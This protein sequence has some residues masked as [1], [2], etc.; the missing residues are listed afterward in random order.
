V[1]EIVE[2]ADC[3]LGQLI[4]AGGDDVVCLVPADAALEVAAKLREAFRDATK[5]TDSISEKPDAS[6]GIAIAHIHAPLQDLIREAQKAEKRAKTDV[7]RPAF[8]VTLMKRS[9]EISQWGSKWDSGGMKLYRAIAENLKPGGLSAK[10]PHRVCQRLTPYLSAQTK[11]MDE[12]KAMQDTITDIVVAKDLISREFSHAAERQGAKDLAKSLAAALGE[13]L[14][15]IIKARGLR[16][17]KTRKLSSRSLFQEL[18]TSVIDLCT[19]VAF[20]D[21]T[22]P[23]EKQPVA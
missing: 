3:L 15:G 4:Y 10:F 17:K 11:Q 1:R 5:G 23:A 19:T 12:Q 6:A 8:S 7:G 2:P 9:G 16:E 21:R 20:A 22:K 18:L 14:E 13:Y